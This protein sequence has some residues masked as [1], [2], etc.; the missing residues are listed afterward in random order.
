MNYRNKYYKYKNKYNK[1]INEIG[2]GGLEENKDIVIK[3]FKKMDDNGNSI[4]T[5]NPVNMIYCESWLHFVA[6]SLVWFL[7]NIGINYFNKSLDNIIL[8]MDN[9]KSFI[10]FKD[11]NFIEK[12]DV[13]EL[14]IDYGN[15]PVSDHYLVKGY[16]LLYNSN[17]ETYIRLGSL[18]LEDLCRKNKNESLERQNELFNLLGRTYLDIICFQEIALK[19]DKNNGW[20]TREKNIEVIKN[21][22]PSFDL[23]KDEYTSIFGYDKLKWKLN[24]IIEIRRV[25]E[26]EKKSNAYRLECLGSYMEIIVVNIHLKAGMF[27]ESF[28]MKELKYIYEIIKYKS[29]DFK[30]PVFLAGDFN[31]DFIK[32][33]QIIESF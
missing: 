11:A 28:R 21:S 1:L 6:G 4:A 2:G 31:Q 30:I 25:G 26:G 27:E 13:N 18:N 16:F 7:N 3:S 24:E 19:E 20:E 15:R 33:D 5:Q 14:T 8:I 9:S 22:L 23:I 17:I 29:Y 32:I 12:S 10:L